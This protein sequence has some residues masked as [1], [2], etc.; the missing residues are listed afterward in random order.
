MKGF[1]RLISTL[2]VLSILFWSSYGQNPVNSDGLD[3]SINLKSKAL[4]LGPKIRLGDIGVFSV[5]DSTSKEK[6]S[7]IEL[8]NAP[9]PGETREISIYYIKRCLKSE[10]LG[11]FAPR[12]KG[13]KTIRVTTAPVEVNKA[14][15]QDNTACRQED[16]GASVGGLIG[17]IIF[18]S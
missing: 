1:I 14:I 3:V 18:T 8:G 2:V 16:G 4:V 9:P 12:L 15:L 13:P 7:A 5:P 17:P 11:Q 10:G 6:L